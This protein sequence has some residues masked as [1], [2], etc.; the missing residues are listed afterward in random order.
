MSLKNTSEEK[1]STQKKIPKNFLQNIFLK[2]INK[3]TDGRHKE[4]NS[5]FF[6]KKQKCVKKE[7]PGVS[8]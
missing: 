2:K 4:Y 1:N 5:A 7:L 6:L 8:K 3:Y